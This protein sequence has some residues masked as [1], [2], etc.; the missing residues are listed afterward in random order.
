MGKYVNKWRCP[1]CNTTNIKPDYILRLDALT[2]LGVVGVGRTSEPLPQCIQCGFKAEVNAMLRGEYDYEDKIS[3]DQKGEEEP[4]ILSNVSTPSVGSQRLA[5]FIVG[6]IFIALVCLSVVFVVGIGIYKYSSKEPIIPSLQ[7]TP[8]PLPTQRT[9]VATATKA[10]DVRMIDA[11]EAQQ[12]AESQ[13]IP[14]LARKAVEQYSDEELNE[15]GA[16]RTYTIYLDRSEPLSWGTGWCTTT[17]AI[18]AQ[19][20][21]HIRYTFIL[22]GKEIPID[23]FVDGEYYSENMQ[24]YCRQYYTIL[25]DWTVGEHLI[26]TIIL[27]DQPLND[28]WDDYP[29]GTKTYEYHVIVSH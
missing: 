2:H 14:F 23:Q 10:P 29:A 20:F 6:G 8:L 1:R 12:M 13:E 3:S 25:T 4:K 28:G 27:Y 18:L 7:P 16:T 11:F 17:E 26:K 5:L 15:M 21:D 22:N 24:G 19:N 9:N